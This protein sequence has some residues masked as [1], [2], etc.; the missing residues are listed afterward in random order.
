VLR[1]AVAVDDQERVVGVLHDVLEDSDLTAADL[2]GEGMS[3]DE[4]SALKLVTR[5]PAESYDQFIERIATAEGRAG[6][7]AQAVKVA[8]VRDNLS[9]SIPKHP[10][11]AHRYQQALARLT[12]D[13]R[14][15]DAGQGSKDR[16]EPDSLREKLERAGVEIIQPENEGA[17]GVTFLGP[18]GQPNR[19]AGS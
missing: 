19:P 2:M 14:E 3:G 15:A 1:V 10:D 13:E 11:L 16:A 8:D 6:R 5:N 4:L 9:R 12:R 7:I 17:T 18:K